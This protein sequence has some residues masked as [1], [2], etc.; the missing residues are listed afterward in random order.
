MASDKSKFIKETNQRWKCILT[1]WFTTFVA[2]FLFDVFRFYYLSLGRGVWSLGSYL[3]SPKMVSEQLFVPVA[4]LFVYWISGYYNH[5]LERSRLNEFLTTFYSQLFNT[6]VIYLA[7]LTNDP[8]YMRRESWLLIIILFL[9]LFT[10]VY[11]GRLLL[12]ENLMRRARRSVTRLRTVIVGTSP[13]AAALAARISSP[14]PNRPR[15]QIVAALPFGN[16]KT[17][18]AIPD[19]FL[20]TPLLKDIEDLKTISEEGKIDQV[21]IVPSGGKSIPKKV[22]FYLYHLYPFDISIKINPD[23]FSLVTPSI[24]LQDILGEPLVDISRPQISE[25]TKNVKRTFDVAASLFGLV[26]LSP[27][28]LGAAIGVKLSSPGSIIYA[29]ERVGRHRRPFR[30][31]KFRSMVSGAEKD[32]TPRLSADSDPRITRVGKWLRKYRIDELPQFW[33]VLKGDMSLVG[34]RPERE[35]FIKQIMKKAPWYTLVLQVRPG[36]TS[37][38]MVKYGYATNIDQMIERNRYDLIYLSNM[39]VA[40]DFKILIHTVKTVGEGKGK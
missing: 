32:G 13:E 29:Q 26:V 10:F 16:E 37:W 11:V 2:F 33:N 40:V 21:I 14:Q 17:D 6:L 30:I 35:Y 19:F 24:R 12:T 4:L 28:M 25:F 27:L 3:S 20:Q 15:A 38:G 34:P 7:A 1:D 39:S 36:I 8:L 5:P 9:L 31:Y 18:D 22:L 23:I